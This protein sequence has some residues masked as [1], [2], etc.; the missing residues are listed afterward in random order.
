MAGEKEPRQAASE[1]EAELQRFF[2]LTAALTE[3]KHLVATVYVER[4][5]AHRLTITFP[6]INA[7][8]QVSFLVSGENKSAIVK[9]LLGGHANSTQYSAGKI[10]PAGGKLA[11]FV[12]QD[13]ASGRD[14]V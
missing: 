14:T 9:A 8:A 11:W 10:I 1:Y 2:Q 7:A 5:K 13:A 4:L 6:V 12:T 3:D